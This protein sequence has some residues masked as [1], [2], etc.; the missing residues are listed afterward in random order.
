MFNPFMYWNP[1]HDLFN[2]QMGMNMGIGMNMGSMPVGMGMGLDM[3]NQCKPL[4][5]DLEADNKC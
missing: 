1:Y 5:I 2:I 4:V 3:Y